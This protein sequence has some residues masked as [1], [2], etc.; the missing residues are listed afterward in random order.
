MRRMI[1]A[2]LALVLSMGVSV[3]ALAGDWPRF[4]GPNGTGIAEEEKA[5]P[6][7]WSPTKNL[8][9]KAKL[10]GPGVS[11]PI[12]VGDRVFVTCYS[13]YGVD[14]RNPGK[15][16]D[17]RRHLLCLNRKTGKVLWE[18]TVAAK[19]PEDPFSGLGVPAHGYASHTPVSDGKNVYVFF[20]K[21]GALAFDME[22]KELWRKH[23]GQE[24]DPK[25]WGSSSSP[26]LFDDMVIVTAAAESRS[27]VALDKKTGKQ[28]WKAEASGLGDVWGTP[29]ITKV[30]K[31]S[32]LVIGTPSEVW[33][34][35]PKTGKLL[36]YNDAINASNSSVVVNDGVIYAVEGRS[37]GSGAIR[38]GGK[39]DTR[40]SNTVWTG[41]HTNRFATPVVYEGRVYSVTNGVLTCI[42]AKD[43]KTIY[44]E[45]MQGGAA[46]GG[47]RGGRGSG[48]YSSPVIANGNLYYVSSSGTTYVAKTGDSFELIAANR[49]SDGNE[50]FAATP[51]ISDGQIF[52]RSN[53]TLYCV[54]DQSK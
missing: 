41:R 29:I 6:T 47:G 27:I 25:R 39:D 42:D 37:G 21:T 44:Q 17:L 46:G 40:K 11:S 54:A 7:E 13:G 3:T 10:P 23:L 36:W 43:G 28:L 32:E 35:D 53:E 50:S 9:W 19:L 30:D 48:D 18:K 2:T 20:G 15:I 26:I 38:V 52:L 5:L 16:E 31:K 12:V 4:R 34:L 22:G 24:S 33:G 45:R 49:V 51:A 8:Q 14:R 1:Y